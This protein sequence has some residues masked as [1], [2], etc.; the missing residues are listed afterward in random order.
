MCKLFICVFYDFLFIS[1]DWSE[2][3]LCM[4]ER[5][6]RLEPLLYSCKVI[7]FWD[8]G[9]FPKQICVNFDPKNVFLVYFNI[10]PMALIFPQPAS[11]LVEFKSAMSMCLSVG[12]PY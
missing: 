8:C 10:L 5:S 4:V 12:P 3:S 7:Q 11:W 2:M 9:I 1:M 6:F